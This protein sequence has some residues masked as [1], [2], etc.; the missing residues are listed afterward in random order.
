MSACTKLTVHGINRLFPKEC[1]VCSAVQQE[2]TNIHA[3][4]RV[5]YHARTKCAVGCHSVYFKY[6]LYTKPYSSYRGTMRHDK[7]PQLC[8]LDD[9]TRKTS[10]KFL[11]CFV[12]VLL[13][14]RV[15]LKPG[16]ATVLCFTIVEI[17]MLY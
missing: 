17:S 7:M 12:F 4:A 9:R 2:G 16:N 8:T 13:T 5:R 6:L 15:Q 3:V 1:G 11:K 10:H 14:R